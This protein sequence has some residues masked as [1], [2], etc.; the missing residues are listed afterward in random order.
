MQMRRPRRL[1]AE[2]IR[3]IDQPG[4]YGDGRGGFGLSLLVQL[5]G[6]GLVK[7]WT[8]RL[9]QRNGRPTS[10]G[11]GGYPS[12]S[13]A[14]ARED[15]ARN[16]LAVKAGEDVLGQRRDPS[17]L[18]FQQAAES[19]ILT[20]AP[21]WKTA[22]TAQVWRTMLTT[23]VYPR[24]GNLPI[25]EVTNADV[26]KVLSPVWTN[27]RAMAGKV[28]TAL[29]AIFAWAVAN[30][31]VQ[32]NPV[33]AVNGALPKAGGKV[34]HHRAL[35]W[36]E[37]PAMLATVDA[38]GAADT[39]KACVRFL[40]LTACRS[41][42]VRGATWDEV[43]GAVWTI[44]G[45]RTK[46][47]KAHRVPLSSA[48]LAVLEQARGL[49]GGYGLIFPSRTGRALSEGALSK[50]FGELGI[51]CVPH[52]LRST[53]RVWASEADVPREVAEFA[54]AHVVGSAAEQAYM[55]GD[56]FRQRVDVMEQ[57]GRVLTD[58]RSLDSRCR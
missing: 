2:F 10:I 47:G 27:R 25:N 12:V 34:Q 56:L 9:L 18:T 30:D 54:L 40:V 20:Y 51:A 53:F 14:E 45:M 3:K 13:L 24:I 21:G 46:T 7:S 52:G 57:W 15:A 49:T 35:P 11:L 58:S 17:M 23:Y 41:G 55:R 1:N 42:E 31:L 36:E 26:F 48:A 37:V 29:N 28:K 50:L 5:S 19:A 22:K 32:V 6:R 33:L 39:T 44:P 43:D 16:I 38:S 4:R 8:Q